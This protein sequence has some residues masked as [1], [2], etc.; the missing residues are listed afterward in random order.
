MD[1]ISVIAPVYKV[2]KYLEK[3]IESIVN[4]TYRNLEIVLIDDGSP[5]NCPAICD[6][7]SKKDNRI[8]V[9][10]KKNGGLSDARNAGM[11]ISTGEYIAFVDSDDWIESHYIEYLYQAIQETNAEISACEVREVIDGEAAE[12]VL[13]E[14]LVFRENS[15]KEAI[16]ELLKGCGFRAVAWN[17][18][19]KRS[20]LEG[21][22]FEVGRLHEDEFFSYRI[23]DKASVL[24]FV[25]IP[26]YNYRQRLGSIMTTF[27]VYHLD[28]LDAYLCRL[29]LLERK[30]PDLASRD[31]VTICK[32]CIN[33]YSEILSK[34][35]D[36][37]SVAKKRI[38]KCRAQIKF[39]RQE[40]LGY[41][42]KDKVY[43]VGSQRWLIEL[44]CRLR[45]LKGSH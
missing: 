1:L 38:K 27:T 13:D 20:L 3:C 9:I 34:S 8:K 16:E 41:S 44:F 31:K 30:Y 17:K 4:Q 28:A 36:D 2:E 18:L 26:L 10:H 32:S 40:W 11:E 14:P 6:N 37:K 35:C 12:P 29:K 42:L 45:V 19:Y 5:D 7:W 43:A 22:R 15:P 21:E 24:A 33:F 39:R 23:L 25:D